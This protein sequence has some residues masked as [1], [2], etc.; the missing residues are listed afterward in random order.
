MT[1]GELCDDGNLASGDGCDANCAPTGCGNGVID[2]G[3]DCD[4]GDDDDTNAC[5]ND[6][7]LLH[8]ATASCARRG[9]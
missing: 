8:A 6:C 7:I 3:E 4:D 1:A 9:V 5:P 2:A